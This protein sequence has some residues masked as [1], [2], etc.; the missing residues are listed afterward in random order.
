MLKR[1]TKRDSDQVK[2]TFVLSGDDARLPAAVVGDFNSWDEEAT[3][4]RRRSNGTWSAAV[5]VAR[6]GRFRFRY[7]S[8]AGEWF[9]E[10]EADAFEPGE[11]GA[12]NG[13]IL[14]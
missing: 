7:R 14:T 8:H 4:F 6:G 12:D 1:T 5:T 3:P 9:D 2:I 11:F 13:V 10:P